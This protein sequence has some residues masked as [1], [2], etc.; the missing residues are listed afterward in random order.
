MHAIGDSVGGVP[1]GCRA[2]KRPAQGV[3]GTRWDPT[4]RVLRM[5]N[6]P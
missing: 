5:T 6:T 4:Q 3:W 1:L 2:A